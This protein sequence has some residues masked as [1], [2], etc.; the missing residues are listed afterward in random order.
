MF[1]SCS[2]VIGAGRCQATK[3]FWCQGSVVFE[4]SL[5][6]GLLSPCLFQERPLEGARASVPLEAREK[7]TPHA[8]DKFWGG[9]LQR[10]QGKLRDLEGAD[11]GHARGQDWEPLFTIH[12]S[13][14]MYEAPNGHSR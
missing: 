6:L 9:F 13:L 1:I 12:S 2:L 4:P 8:V 5:Q 3:L 11:R 10:L 7:P 14:S